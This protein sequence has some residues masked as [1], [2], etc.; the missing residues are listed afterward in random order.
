MLTLE[1]FQLETPQAAIDLN[2]S[3]DLDGP[4]A[5]HLTL[6]TPREGLVIEEVPAEVLDA[7]TNDEGWVSIPLRVTGT[8]DEPTVLP[9]S[10]ALMAGQGT[11][12]LLEQGVKSFFQERLN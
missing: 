9:D 10:K 4:L 1:R 3:V 5:L 11:K 2:G 6:R 7:L 8:R 12:R